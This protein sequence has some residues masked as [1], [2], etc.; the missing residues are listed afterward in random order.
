MDD[1]EGRRVIVSN[2]PFVT[3]QDD[4]QA[5]MERAGQVTF[6]E[7]LLDERGVSRGRAI[8]EY[9]CYLEA[10]HA[11][12]VLNQSRLQGRTL[13]VKLQDSNF[14]PKVPPTM[15]RPC[16]VT[17]MNM[18]PSVTWQ[19]LKEVFRI[20][21]NV[22]RSEVVLDRN[23]HSTGFGYVLFEKSEDAN[24]AVQMFNGCFFNGSKLEVK[25]EN[26]RAND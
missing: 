11:A 18:P 5:H 10:R 20:C 22:F 13:L 4:I 3:T 26:E 6:I 21:G 7:M 25:L 16:K 24:A 1:L 19:Q 15:A 14:V 2:I 9:T 23:W 17:V 8:V 12:K